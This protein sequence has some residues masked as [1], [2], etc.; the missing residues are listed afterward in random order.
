MLF[1]CSRERVRG[2]G[3]VSEWLSD[4]G[5][6]GEIDSEGEAKRDAERGGLSVHLHLSQ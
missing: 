4:G 2:R 3:R 1:A 5:R 6:Q